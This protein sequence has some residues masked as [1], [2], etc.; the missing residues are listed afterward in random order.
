M[1]LNGSLN[2]TQGK[3]LEKDRKRE[4]EAKDEQH[5]LSTDN[6][7]AI[8]NHNNLSMAPELIF[9]LLFIASHKFLELWVCQPLL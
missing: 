7:L 2:K 8:Q 6:P 4:K 1:N 5:C 9:L 3:I